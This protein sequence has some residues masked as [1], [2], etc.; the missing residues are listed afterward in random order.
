M[1]PPKP[2]NMV[3]KDIRS[4]Y[5]DKAFAITMQRN[6]LFVISIVLFLSVILS[7]VIIKAIVEKK[8]VEPYVIKVTDQEQIPISVNINSIINYANA[9]QGVVE[10]FLIQYINLREGYNF[11][12]Y[13]YD[14]NSVIKRMSDDNTFRAF[15]GQI[16]A[17]DGV[18]NT[19][20]RN[21]IIDV[22]IQQIAIE[23]K[24]NIAFIRIAKRL[25]QNGVVRRISNFRIKMHY[26]FNSTGLNYRDIVL[27]PLG[28]KVDFYEVVEEV[29]VNNPSF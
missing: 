4:W 26:S 16:N 8:G 11:F 22:A 6:I 25:T 13:N 18:I 24:N 1:K 29:A 20:G 17:P 2:N 5:Q 12:T 9:N 3:K 7:L 14:Y 19:L 10:Y 27:N 15:S 28:L 23:P 21:G